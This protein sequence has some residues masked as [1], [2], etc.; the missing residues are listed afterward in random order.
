MDLLI[1]N[2]KF[3]SFPLTESLIWYKVPQKACGE[4]FYVWCGSDPL[5]DPTL[6]PK[7]DCDPNLTLKVI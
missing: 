5:P 7:E 3:K 6:I 4:D 1:T 2:L